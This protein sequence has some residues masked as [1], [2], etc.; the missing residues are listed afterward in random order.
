MFKAGCLVASTVSSQMMSA[1]TTSLKSSTTAGLAGLEDL[2]LVLLLHVRHTICSA[3]LMTLS[4][5]PPNFKPDQ[6]PSWWMFPKFW[7]ILFSV[8]ATIGLTLPLK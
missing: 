6:L 4:D 5:A 1:A 2:A 7:C 8:E 3:A